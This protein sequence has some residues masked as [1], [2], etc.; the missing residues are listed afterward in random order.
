MRILYCTPPA[1]AVTSRFWQATRMALPD[2]QPNLRT[3]ASGAVFGVCAVVAMVAIAV[4]F[5][6]T[7]RGTGGR[8]A[9]AEQAP[10][11]GFAPSAPASG[12]ILRYETE[13]PTIP[14][15]TGKRTDAVAALIERL[16]RGEMKL[17][18]DGERGYL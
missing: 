3:G 15:L 7:G 14:Y 12:S 9:P 10:L 13:Y 17:A 1:V 2:R 16:E 18:Y 8:S 11:L 5:A 6:P 4:A